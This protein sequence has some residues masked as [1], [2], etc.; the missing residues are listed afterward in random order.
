MQVIILAAG[1]STRTYPL[2]KTRPKPLLKVVNKTIIE[3]NL[4][5]LEEL[6]DEVIVITGYQQEMIKSHLGEK[7]GRIKLSFIEQKE[8]NGSGGALLCVK[9]KLRDRFL[10]LNGDDL[11]SERDFKKLVKFKY[12]LLAKEVD[13]PGRF[14]VLK[15][16]GGKLLDFEEKP[17]KPKSNLVNS[18]AYIFDKKIFNYGLKESRR[19]E[20]EI[21]DYIRHLIS[22]G[23]NFE[24]QKVNDFWFPIT[25]PWSLFE[26]NQYFLNQL[27][28]E[29]KGKIEKGATVKGQIKIG[30][31]TVIKSGVYLEGPIL[32][33]K[34]CSI[35]PNCYLR[36]YTILGDNCHIGQAVELKNAIVGDNTNIAHL[37]YVGDSI[38]GENVN[39]GAG[40]ITANLR[41]DGKTIRTPVKG[42]LVD[43][44][45]R[46][47]GVIVGDKVKT[48][49]HTSFYPGVKIDPMAMT[50]P[51]EVVTRDKT[52]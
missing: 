52:L 49:I 14:G 42:E 22:Q 30:K 20:L 45:L 46:K 10:V 3:H 51:G 9:N 47:L 34:N 28:T 38:I 31:N 24:C 7:F 13:D 50:L 26:P 41:H 39:F 36:S 29:I 35:G 8:R 27:K 25:Y 37:S 16:K 32:I 4:S 40:A 1:E 11:Y 48:G 17:K 23:E 44:G 5:Q 21:I 15:V 43:S 33:G 2:T 18:G 12:A 19:G 6:T